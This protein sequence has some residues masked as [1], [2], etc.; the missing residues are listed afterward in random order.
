[1][2]NAGDGGTDAPPSDRPTLQRAKQSGDQSP[3]KRV[4][5]KKSRPAKK[6]AS[7]SK[8]DK[9]TVDL[10]TA[11]PARQE[12]ASQGES[13]FALIKALR[14]K[15]T[16]PIALVSTGIGFLAS[17]AQFVNDADPVGLL[18]KA[19]AVGL[20]VVLLVG[21]TATAIYGWKR[22]LA[23]PVPILL[24]L[25][26]TFGATGVV[27]GATIEP[28]GL[29]AASQSG[30]RQ[31]PGAAAPTGALPT[32]ASTSSP[33]TATSS[34]PT[35][36]QRNSLSPTAPVAA[37]TPTPP[38]GAVSTAGQ[39]PPNAA[40]TSS[41]RT[42]TTKPPRSTAK[43]APKAA[44]TKPKTGDRVAQ[45]TVLTGTSSNLPAGMTLVT[46]KHQSGKTDWYVERPASWQT[47][48][49]LRSW[50]DTQTFN[51]ADGESFTL[52]VYLAPLDAVR[53][54]PSGDTW[55]LP[56]IPE[57]WSLLDQ[58]DVIADYSLTPECSG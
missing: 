3:P 47:P 40:R 21:G 4:S 31:Q 58:A 9:E 27:V 20:G 49:K 5:P 15:V 12:S 34:P 11:A 53:A 35:T 50:T 45:C 43:P 6:A 30:E 26:T 8:K 13:L 39:R 56:A 28:R 23:V 10:R 57:G 52:Y 44:L 14:L 7:G 42:S 33:V 51:N 25:A 54:K 17:V 1:M 18:T 36:D 32:K 29:L 46:I 2:S 16:A 55:A 37:P 24:L 48:S 38:Q 19:A 41:T 22:R